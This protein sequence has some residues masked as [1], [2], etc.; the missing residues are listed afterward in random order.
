MKI[1]ELLVDDN[2]ATEKEL[3]AAEA[4]FKAL[5]SGPEARRLMRYYY[6][7]TLEASGVARAKGLKDDEVMASAIAAAAM[8]A[9]LNSAA[10]DFVKKYGAEEAMKGLKGEDHG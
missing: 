3:E 8:A 6:N 5:S 2:L 7:I 1:D 10:Y 9:R 4:V